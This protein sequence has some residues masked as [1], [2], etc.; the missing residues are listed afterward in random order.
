[1]SKK[2]TYCYDL[3]YEGEAEAGTVVNIKTGITY[4]DL[5]KYARVS[6]CHRMVSNDPISNSALWL[7]N[8]CIGRCNTSGMYVLLDMRNESFVEPWCLYANVS[9]INPKYG[10][11]LVNY[12]ETLKRSLLDIEKDAIKDTDEISFGNY[13]GEKLKV[14]TKFYIYGVSKYDIVNIGLHFILK[15]VRPYAAPCSEA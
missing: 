5:K 4:A 3:L 10:S 15:N 2:E 8:K 13:S 14:D 12:P 11:A 1:M 7:G 6:I 9:L